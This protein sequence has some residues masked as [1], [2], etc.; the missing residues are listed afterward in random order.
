VGLRAI[1]RATSLGTGGENVLAELRVE[2][3]AVMDQLAVEFA[4]GLNLL[5][6]ETGAGKSLL[7]DALALLLGEKASPE[8]IRHGSQKAVLTGVFAPVHARL[9]RLLDESGL[10]G[11]GEVE[12]H[13]IIRREIAAGGKGRVFINDQPATVAVLR[14]LAPELAVV[15]AQH[16][17]LRG[18]DAGARLELL[19]QFAGSDASETSQTFAAWKALRERIAELERSE[20]D[21]L[22]M[23]DLWSFQKREIEAAHLE[24][25]PHSNEDERLEG[26]RRILANAEKIYAAAMGAYGALYESSGSALESLRTAMR[27]VNELAQFDARFAE[28][29]TQLEAARIA[30]DDVSATLRD[31]AGGVNASPERLVEIEDRLATLERLKR[32]YGRTLDEVIAFGAEVAQKLGEIEHRDDLLRDLRAELAK[33][34][35]QY[36]N[37]ARALSRKRAAAAREL[38]KLVEAETNDLAMKVRF[39]AELASSEDEAGWSAAGFDAVQFQFAATPGEPLRPLEDV[40][41]GGELSRVMLALKVVIEQGTG[42]ASKKNSRLTGRT[43]VFDEI[44]IGIGGRAADAVGKKLKSLARANQVLCVTHL[45]QIAAFADH[46]YLISKREAAGPEG[47]VKSRTSIRRL[48]AQERTQ[49]L[50][51]ML[52]GAK[53]TDASLKN[54][55]QMLKANA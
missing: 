31:F 23:A 4:P 49:E 15:H 41:S 55:E 48:E 40:A 19:D 14:Q 47:K 42:K 10:A 39:R 3:Y 16:E 9:A 17:S 8:V 30:M 27:Q 50:A 35:E 24:P 52:S 22:R 11:A 45:P 21:R 33:A 25:G 43:L 26:E 46:H 34:A 20:Q 1:L 29:N 38:E 54:A 5:T 36:L 18:L 44:D 51:R 13:V 32:K 28:A 53:V 12:D 37:A 2:N 7:V 6:G